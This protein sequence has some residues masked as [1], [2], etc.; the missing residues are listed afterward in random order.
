[1]FGLNPEQVVGTIRQFLPFFSGIATALGVTWFDGVASAVLATIGPLM[2]LISL[3]WS[4]VSKTQA[5]T[6]IAAKS[7][8]DSKGQ[9]IVEQI[10]LA[11]TAAGMKLQAQTPAG[12]VVPNTTPKSF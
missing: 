1:M 4:L 2:G 9:P 10:N 7:M 3:V 12:I 6:L 8:V 11:P 5:N